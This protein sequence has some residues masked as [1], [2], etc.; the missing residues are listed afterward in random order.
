MDDICAGLTVIE[1]GSCSVAGAMA[2]MILADAGARV[3]K[4]EPPRGDGLRQRLPSGFLVWNRGK[5]SVVA[6]LETP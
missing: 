5:E 1:I 2:G 3:I 6:D 4:I